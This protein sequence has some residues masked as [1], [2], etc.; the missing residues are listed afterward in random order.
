VEHHGA[1]DL[2]NRV[3]VEGTGKS[4][5]LV[6]RRAEREDVTAL[7]DGTTLALDLLR[8]RIE[9]GSHEIAGP[10]ERRIVDQQ[11]A[12]HINHGRVVNEILIVS[13]A[14]DDRMDL[15][16]VRH[17]NRLDPGRNWIAQREGS[18]RNLHLFELA[19]VRGGL[20]VGSG[21]QQANAQCE[22]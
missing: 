11:G 7:V 13:Q 6:E 12:P 20:G 4:Q 22:R 9:V 2:T 5:V 21:Q 1:S 14:E 3:T 19:I 10:R 18:R 16:D 15:A 8:A 17:R